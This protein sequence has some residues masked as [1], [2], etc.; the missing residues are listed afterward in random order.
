MKFATVED[1]IIH[2]LFAGRPVDIE[3]VKGIVNQ[4]DDL[5][6]AY[7]KKWLNEFSAVVDKDLVKQFE[8]I[9]EEVRR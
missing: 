5:D 9:K 6:Q 8:A 7:L 4:R 2:K 1:T 3:D